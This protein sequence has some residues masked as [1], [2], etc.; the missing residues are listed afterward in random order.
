MCHVQ[1][2]LDAHSVKYRHL[3]PALEI[4][5]RG[6]KHIRLL[7][8]PTDAEL[9]VNLPDEVANQIWDVILIDAPKLVRFESI[10]TTKRLMEKYC[11]GLPTCLSKGNIVHVLVHD[12]ERDIEARWADRFFGRDGYT[13][14][15]EF[16]KNR[17]LVRMRHYVFR[18]S[19]DKRNATQHLRELGEFLKSTV[20]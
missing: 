1:A 13:L 16:R 11:S 17:R 14:V 9:L 5:H 2:D 6:E 20:I 10:W 19:S 4:P 15:E 3:A 18:S 8:T 12:S 7:N